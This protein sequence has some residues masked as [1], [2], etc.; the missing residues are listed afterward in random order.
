MDPTGDELREPSPSLESGRGI[1]AIGEDEDGTVYATDL[2]GGEL[3]RIV[4][5]RR[6]S[7][8]ARLAAGEP[9]GDGH[10]DR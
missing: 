6:R 7:G 5:A 10:R 8:R 4:S 3:L 2:N 1:S 9:E